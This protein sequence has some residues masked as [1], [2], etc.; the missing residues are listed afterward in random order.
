MNEHSCPEMDYNAPALY[1]T[2]ID[3][4]QYYESQDG[5]ILPGW[6]ATNYEYASRIR[7]CPWCGIQLPEKGE[8]A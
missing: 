6:Y 2:A 3:M 7:Y 5:S 1:G 4:I 8:R